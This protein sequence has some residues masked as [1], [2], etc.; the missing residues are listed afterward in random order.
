MVFS[1]QQNWGENGTTSSFL[2]VLQFCFFS[3]H[4]ELCYSKTAKSLNWLISALVFLKL[5]S[6]ETIMFTDLV[7]QRSLL[8]CSWTYQFLGFFGIIVSPL[9]GVGHFICCSGQS[10]CDWCNRIR[11]VELW[12]RN[13]TNNRKQWVL[14]L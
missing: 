5:T 10:L 3:C 4:V 1:I 7:S 2:L 9:W 8:C 14:A 11:E 6:T 13:Q 12:K